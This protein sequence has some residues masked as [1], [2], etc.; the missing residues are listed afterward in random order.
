[1]IRNQ[2]GS[3]RCNLTWMPLNIDIFCAKQRCLMYKEYLVKYKGCHHKM[4]IWWS[5]LTWTTYLKWW[6]NLNRR[7][8]T[9]WSEKN[10]K[11]CETFFHSILAIA[12]NSCDLFETFIVITIINKILD[13]LVQYLFSVDNWHLNLIVI[14][15]IITTINKTWI[16]WCNTYLVSKIDT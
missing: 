6:P 10:M 14:F 16:I 12:W 9:T 13:N 3:K 4:A 11:K 15:I 2:I 1:M 5:L 7:R 8:G